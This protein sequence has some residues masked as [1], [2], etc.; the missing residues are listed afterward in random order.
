MKVAV[1]LADGFEEIEALTPKDVLSRV[2]IQCDLISIKGNVEVTGAN[3]VTVLA[4][5]TFN[6]INIGTYDAIVLPGGM[7]GA[8]Y[9]SEDPRVIETVRLFDAAHKIIGAICAA[10][11]LVLPRAGI[12][13]GRKITCYPGMEDNLKQAD[14]STEI[15]AEDDNLI[16]SRG[17]ATAL[18]F[19]YKL[20]EKL[21][22]TSKT[23]SN[24]ML[25]NLI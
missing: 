7:P 12:T 15:V 21:G 23:V 17:P 3:G 22:K 5:R 11:A 24:G 1:L 10:P 16:T 9:L 8:K 25:Y 4:D 18:A 20:V 19:S 14:F 6:E 2:Q 13:R